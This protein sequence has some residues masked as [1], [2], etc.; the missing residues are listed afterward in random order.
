LA[1]LFAHCSSDDDSDDSEAQ[2][3]SVEEAKAMLANLQEKKRK[4]GE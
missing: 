2:F 1:I 3:K 4:R